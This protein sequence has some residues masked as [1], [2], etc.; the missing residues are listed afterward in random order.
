MFLI[1]VAQTG[2]APR[3]GCATVSSLT[4]QGRE[5]RCGQPAH[6][7]P[8]PQPHLSPAT[9]TLPFFTFAPFATPPSLF[10]YQ[11]CQLSVPPC[12][13]VAASRPPTSASAPRRPR[14]FAI[15][16][17]SA[18]MIPDMVHH[19]SFTDAMASIG[20]GITHHSPSSSLMQ[21]SFL[22]ADLPSD[23]IVTVDTIVKA[24]VKAAEKEGVLLTKEDLEWIRAD[25][26]K[27][28]ADLLTY[29]RKNDLF[30]IK[31]D[32]NE[33]SAVVAVALIAGGVAWFDLKQGIADLKQGVA[34]LLNEQQE[35]V[36][37]DVTTELTVGAG[38]IAVI[39]VS[40]PKQLRGFKKKSFTLKSKNEGKVLELVFSHEGIV[41]TW[42]QH[43]PASK[44]VELEEQKGV[45]YNVT[46]VET[47]SDTNSPS[48]ELRIELKKPLVPR[49]WRLL[50]V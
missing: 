46:N 27:T 2:F 40:A 14:P 5:G 11:P 39:E 37:P 8:N 44:I 32:L 28:E 29:P 1:S 10:T 17:E 38:N 9:P 43:L 6:T 20:S 48:A 50:L 24:C 18:R 3:G 16:D 47:A 13:R 25:L 35:R 30:L 21:H 12:T 31:D 36:L 19:L 45:R 42:Q 23:T 33:L 34:G 41:Q 26:L 49:P 15:L 7:S 4:F 22:V